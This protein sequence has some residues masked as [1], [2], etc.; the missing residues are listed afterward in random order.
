MT[1]SDRDREFTHR[2]GAKTYDAILSAAAEHGN[3][4]NDVEKGDDVF[5]WALLV[6]I[7]YEC[8]T[9]PAF[10]AYHEIAHA[11]AI[12]AWMKEPAQRA[13]IAAHN[14]DMDYL[15]MFAGVY[16][17]FMPEGIAP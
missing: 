16:N 3:G 9:R 12:V 10:I 5:R 13:W 14:G 17:Q 11:D 8:L 1:A 2:F 15:A 7:G 6:C 4:I